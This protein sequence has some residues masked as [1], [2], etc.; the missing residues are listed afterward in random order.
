MQPQSIAD[1]ARLL[2]A[3][4]HS[5]NLLAA[6]PPACQPTNTAEAHAIQDATV[7]ALGDAVAGWKI[8]L[9]PDG[10]VMRGVLLRSRVLPSPARIK[11][12]QVPLLGVEAEIAFHFDRALAPR[13]RDYSHGEVAAAVAAFAAIEVVDT[14]FTSYANTPPLQRLAD[15]MSNGAFVQGALQADW[16]E[17]DLVNLHVRLTLDGE[18]I[19]DRIGGHV[20]QDPL[21]PAVA[22]VNELRRQGGVPAGMLM[23]TGTYTGLNH[24]KP[25]QTTVVAFDGFASVQLTFDR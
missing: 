2:I 15:F 3:A 11:A 10:T 22:L 9:A 7:A 1:A 5:G 18:V 6:L 4:R 20:T 8:A 12:A 19:A 25:G 16:R 21:I 13:D 17:L 14:R 23:T 24:A